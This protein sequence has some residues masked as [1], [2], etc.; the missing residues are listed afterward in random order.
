MTNFTQISTERQALKILRNSVGRIKCPKCQ[1]KHYIR[2]LPDGRYY[3]QQCRYKFSFK[4]LMGLKNSKL[5]YLQIVK[6]IHYFSRAESLCTTLEHIGISYQSA[7]ANYSKLRRLL[8][9]E[10][11]KLAGDVIT[12]VMYVGKQKTNNQSLVS[13]AVNREFTYANLEVVP[14]Q[15]QHT[16]ELF[17]F[18]NVD[19]L[20]SLVTT[21]SHPSYN[22][23]KWMGY[24]HRQEN[25]S[26]FELKY[27]V[28]IERLWALFKTLIRRTYHHIWKE[29]LPEYLVEFRARFNHRKTVSDPA[30]LLAYLLNPCSNSLT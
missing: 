22:S 9:N 30:S 12:D 13:G 2:S 8:P 19:H 6:L 1:K 20:N 11:G 16:L 21:D 26:K 3:C 18:K 4:V 28:P 29:K 7:R 10:T 17:L 15:E 5:N 24:G 23:I 27:S 14:D 25:H